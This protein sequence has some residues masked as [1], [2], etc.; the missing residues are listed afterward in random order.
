MWLPWLLIERITFIYHYLPCIPLLIL[1]LCL[2][3]QTR[4]QQTA[5]IIG[6]LMTSLIL[7]GMF[8]PVI[9]GLPVPADYGA[10]LRWLP[11]WKTL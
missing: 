2:W 7:F 6:L 10:S 11:E 9:A 1:A 3:V 5:I 4:K 8:Y